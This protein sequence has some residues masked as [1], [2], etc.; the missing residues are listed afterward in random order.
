MA[1]FEFQSASAAA[2]AAPAAYIGFAPVSTLRSSW[3]TRL[4]RPLQYILEQQHL[5]V[6]A[7]ADFALSS[8]TAPSQSL[9]LPGSSSLRRSK[10]TSRVPAPENSRVA[11]ALRNISASASPHQLP[12]YAP[13]PPPRTEPLRHR[14][15]LRRD[16]SVFSISL[17]ND[18][19]VDVTL[20][21]DHDSDSNGP[22]SDGRVDL[23]FSEA[24]PDYLASIV[25]SHSELRRS[26]WCD[27]H[28]ADSVP[29]LNIVIQIVGS[30]GDVQ[31]FVALAKELVRYGHRVR[32]ATH[33]TFRKF[34]TENGIEFYPLAG[35]PNDLMAYMVKNPGLL[36]GLSSIRAGDVRKKREMIT[37][38]LDSAWNSCVDSDPDDPDATPFEAD[39]IIANPVSF[40][41]IHCA[42]RLMVPCHI[43]F[44]MPWSP[45]TAFSNP[46][47]NVNYSTAWSHFCS[48]ELVDVLTWEGL[49]DIVNNFRKSTLG[50]AKLSPKGGPTIMKVLEVP[51]TY[52]WSEALIPKPA[53]WGAHIDI[54]GFIF[55]DL[56]SAYTPPQDLVDFLAAGPPPVYI[57]FGS[58]VVDDPDALTATIFEAI[59]IANVRAI[60]SKG[61]G[62]LGGAGKDVPDGVYMIGNCPHDWLF[63]QVS[64]VVHHGGAGTTS[65]GLKAGKPT[66]V[67]PF[68]GD[69]SF[70]GAM[71]ASIQAGPPPIPFKKLT[72]D[73]L[74][75]AI[76]FCFAPA[77]VQAAAL[78]GARITAENGAAA[79]ARSF[80]AHLPLD[81]MRCDVDPHRTARWYLP[82]L[83]KKVSDDALAALT[84]RSG[85]EAPQHEPLRFRR[86]ETAG[87][88]LASRNGTLSRRSPSPNPSTARAVVDSAISHARAAISAASAAITP[89][90][91]ILQRGAGYWTARIGEA[92]ANT[93]NHQRTGDDTLSPTS[94]NRL[95]PPQPSARPN[96]DFFHDYRSHTSNALAAAAPPPSSRLPSAEIARP[97]PEPPAHDHA[98]PRSASAPIETALAAPAAAP[99]WERTVA[100]RHAPGRFGVVNVAAEGEPHEWT[101]A[102][103]A[104]RAVVEY[105]YVPPEV[106]LGRRMTEEELGEA[107]A[108]MLAVG[109][110]GGEGGVRVVR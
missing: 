6:E 109:E 59:K 76:Q 54:T 11:R 4:T 51:H 110:G 50:L 79:T 101:L 8:K 77:V 37:A 1:L 89:Q 32:L 18:G 24:P 104:P 35:D 98:L 62:G 31:P 67:V 103:V 43:I 81:A 29:A 68:F 107:A 17:N 100:R 80:H 26:V 99:A 41:H 105:V 47:T 40:A 10:S 34:V 74:A 106:D 83:G 78:A 3:I 97:A 25:Q 5:L 96:D 20:G 84:A 30:R 49:G 38:I 48:Y 90:L 66:V 15:S 45:T 95:A 102:E 94:A 86:W 85:G 33:S 7:L 69:Q 22:S 52:I 93:T 56:A 16:D 14:H 82:T 19:R 70:W 91:I 55:L 23:Q 63:K 64:A 46:L 36:P 27:R 72:A 53:D 65:A 60:V 58:I 75:S 2:A 13:P 87:L 21:S 92:L 73:R 108:R 88:V 39:A 71:I 44:T 12:A 42:E 61:W 9:T 57:G 28:S